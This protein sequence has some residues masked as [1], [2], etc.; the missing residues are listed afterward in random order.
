ML[1]TFET[2]VYYLLRSSYKVIYL[3]EQESLH[4][5]LSIKDSEK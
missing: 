3:R 4:L 5:L 1:D 2:E